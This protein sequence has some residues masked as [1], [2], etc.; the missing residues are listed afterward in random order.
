MLS[1]AHRRHHL[2]IQIAQHSLRHRRIRHPAGEFHER[3]DP[4]DRPLQLADVLRHPPR[5]P[6]HYF[7][8]Q[9]QSAPLR[10]APQNLAP[11]GE[12]GRIY[13][14]HHPADEPVDERFPELLDHLGMIVAGHHHLPAHRLD[15]VESVEEFLLRRFLAAQE[16]HVVDH[17]QVQI[18]H[19]PSEGVDLVAAQRSQEF[20]R[21]FLAGQIRPAFGRMM[22]NESFAQPLKQMGFAKSASAVDEQ[23]VVLGS[24]IFRDIQGRVEGKLIALPDHERFDFMPKPRPGGL[25]DNRSGDKL[26]GLGGPIT[27]NVL[28]APS[29]L[30]GTIAV[31]D[32]ATTGVTGAAIGDAAMGREVIGCEVIGRADAIPASFTLN[33]DGFITAVEALPSAPEALPSALSIVSTSNNCGTTLKRTASKQPSTSCAASWIGRLKCEPI[34]SLIKSLGTAISNPSCFKSR[35][36]ELLNQTWN[37]CCPTRCAIAL[38]NLANCGS[39]VHNATHADSFPANAEA[40]PSAAEALPTAPCPIAPCTTGKA[41][42]LPLSGLPHA[43]PKQTQ[44]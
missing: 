21:E 12:I 6:A 22:R 32:S 20:V 36:V 42:H 23:R 30:A 31:A 40:L 24:R 15:R 13:P 41:Q 43:S 16:V 35:R 28:H 14:H 39:C 26:A 18:A 9:H 2:P 3:R 10:Q 44:S 1:G 29:S 19:L 27:G 37:L 17:Q 5:D 7:F 34:H 8:A 25:R 11:R 38:A 4:S 33:P